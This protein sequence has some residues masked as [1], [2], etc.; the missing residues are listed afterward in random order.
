MEVVRTSETSGYYEV[1]RHHITE[2]CHLHTS[3]VVHRSQIIL[4]S[5]EHNIQLKGENCG[6]DYLDS[7]R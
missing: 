3:F 4:H 2:G 1:T 5:T 6:R 7:Q